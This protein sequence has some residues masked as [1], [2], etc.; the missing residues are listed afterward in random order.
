MTVELLAS[1]VTRRKAVLD[2]CTVFERDDWRAKFQGDVRNWLGADGIAVLPGR[3]IAEIAHVA[4]KTLLAGRDQAKR[5]AVQ[6]RAALALRKPEELVGLGEVRRA[7]LGPADVAQLCRDNAD[8][9]LVTEEWREDRKTHKFR[10]SRSRI[11]C[12]C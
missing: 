6:L 4:T 10:T 12:G 2:T 3:V 7:V 1:P 9:D 11:P 5:D 8:L